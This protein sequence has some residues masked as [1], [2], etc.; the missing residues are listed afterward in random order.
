RDF[1]SELQSNLSGQ[2]L[3]YDQ[4]RAAHN[5][6][7]RLLLTH[8]D[9]Y[10]QLGRAGD[11]L[12]RLGMPRL[13]VKAGQALHFDDVQGFFQGSGLRSLYPIV[14]GLTADQLRGLL[15][16]GTRVLF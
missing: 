8:T 16:G 9:M 1:N 7:G 12:E 3:T 13:Q 10:P 15:S 4:A 11:I 2:P 6:L 5:A 14:A